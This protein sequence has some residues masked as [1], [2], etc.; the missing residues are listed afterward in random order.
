[1][2]KDIDLKDF[3]KSKTLKRIIMGLGALIIVLA[4]LQVGISIGYRK[5][6]FSYGWGNNYYKTFGGDR[7]DRGWASGRGMM[8]MMGPTPGRG[9]SNANGAIGKIVKISLPTF[10]IADRDNTEK[11]ILIGDDTLVR[12]FRDTIPATELK[13]GDDIVVI[14]APN[15]KSEIEARLIRIV[16]AMMLINNA[17]STKL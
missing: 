4:I 10:V 2:Q 8:G 14:G 9:V 7:D 3:V 5:A 13:V 1:M 15:D 17:S 16:P 12:Q 11:I 6:S